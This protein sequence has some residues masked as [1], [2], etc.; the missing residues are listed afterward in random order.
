MAASRRLAAVAAVAV[1]LLVGGARAAETVKEKPKQSSKPSQPA[2]CKDIS[3]PYSERGAG[4]TRS[5]PGRRS[6]ARL[7]AAI[8][9]IRVFSAIHSNRTTFTP[10]PTP[11]RPLPVRVRA[12][13]LLRCA[14]APPRGRPAPPVKLA[15]DQ[16]VTPDGKPVTMHGLSWFG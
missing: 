5:A 9:R 11:P 10:P 12:P 14:A 7:S 15:G 13:S 3:L 6:Q 8:S 16:F 1:L 2:F 4:V